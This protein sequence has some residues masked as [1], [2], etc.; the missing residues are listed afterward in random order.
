MNGLTK[1][2]YYDTSPMIG[3]FSN[4][5]FPCG[6]EGYDTGKCNFNVK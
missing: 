4:H 1:A 6:S 3:E 2:F 5:H